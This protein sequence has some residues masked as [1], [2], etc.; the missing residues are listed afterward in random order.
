VE[1]C[2]KKEIDF[3]KHEYTWFAGQAKK[4]TSERSNGCELSEVIRGKSKH[5]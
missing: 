4:Y 3:L 1:R 2:L 5:T